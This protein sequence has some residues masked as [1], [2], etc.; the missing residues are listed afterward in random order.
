[1]PLHQGDLLRA[2]QRFHQRRQML[3]LRLMHFVHYVVAHYC[4]LG[5]L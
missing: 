3:R 5:C 2:F 4:A 1:M